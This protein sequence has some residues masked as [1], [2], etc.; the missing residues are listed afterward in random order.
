L[1][2][3]V[4]NIHDILLAIALSY[5]LRIIAKTPW[6]LVYPSPSIS[7]KQ[8]SFQQATCIIVNILHMAAPPSRS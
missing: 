4:A 7:S 6:L 1:K 2:S 5:A 8:A 3:D